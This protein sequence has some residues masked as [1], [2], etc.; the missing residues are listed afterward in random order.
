ML[1]IGW[2]A[3]F[4]LVMYRYVAKLGLEKMEA[5]AYTIILILFCYPVLFCLDRG[6]LEGLVLLSSL[7]FAFSL[8]DD[9]PFRAGALLSMGIA[10]KGYP[11]LFAILFFRKP[12]YS[13]FTFTVLSSIACLIIPALFF[14]NSLID[15][16]QHISAHQRDYHLVYGMTDVGIG[17]G[18]SLFSWL[19]M[20]WQVWTPADPID[21]ESLYFIYGP[22]AAACTVL[23]CFIAANRDI[24][25][26]RAALFIF[27]PLLVLPE[28]SFDYKIVQVFVPLILFIG[29]KEIDT[30]FKL[31]IFG[32]ILVPKSY[33]VLWQGE[34][35]DFATANAFLTPLLLIIL[36]AV[37][38]WDIRK[39]LFK[40]EAYS[41]FWLKRRSH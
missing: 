38:L 13:A 7:G 35:G 3:A 21:V 14:P 31:W 9:K 40:I 36:L 8:Q 20:F 26:W 37:C 12:Q 34:H 11:C 22:I 28:V 17:Y 1:S 41:G 2:I 24:P 32:L 25:L 16:F 18:V 30:N 23:L 10:M 39:V 29:S 4:W 15:S 5:A 19:K 33:F 27:V 6:N